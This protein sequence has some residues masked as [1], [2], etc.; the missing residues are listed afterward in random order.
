[1]W[2][3]FSFGSS[4]PAVI[5]RA[6]DRTIGDPT[7]RL[8]STFATYNNKGVSYND[9]IIAEKAMCHPVVYRVIN[10]I[11][12]SVQGI[13]WYCEPVEQKGIPAANSKTIKAIN[14]VLNDP[15]DMMNADQL[16]YWFA[17]N[18]AV[19]GRFAFKVG[20]NIND[21]VGAIYPLEAPHLESIISNTGRLEGWKY[22]TGEDK[23][24]L[25]PRRIVDPQRQNNF[26]GPFAYEYIT[27]GL[28]PSSMLV[29]AKEKNNTPLNTLGLPSEIIT[30]L[31]QRA[32]DTASGRPNLK[33]IVAAEKTLDGKQ[34]DELKDEFDEREVG[35]EKSGNLLL[36]TNTSIDVH[37][38]DDGMADIHSKV[39]LDDM[40]RMIY[41]AFGVPI[42]LGG[43][44]SSD[45]AKFAGNFEASRQSFYEDTLVPAYCDPIAQSLTAALCPP[46]AVVRFD[47]DAV[48]AIAYSRAKKAK[49]LQTITF[50]T[51]QEKREMS[52]FPAKKDKSDASSGPEDETQDS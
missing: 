22:G 27:P 14:A 49:E 4:A 38:L 15:N 8:I 44:G 2:N 21:N 50:L 26:S 34:E 32:H 36:L 13:P 33:H 5:K 35:A 48:P 51:D 45:A 12:L 24:T 18:K 29:K 30:M 9:M 37:T 16:R 6:V 19:F 10:K 42:A 43:I 3:P 25:R 23:E 11:A 7:R 1:M 17:L 31:L 20:R 39:P 46:G 41:A 40:T 47:Y 52:G 28:R